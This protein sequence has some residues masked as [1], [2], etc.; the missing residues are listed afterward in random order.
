MARPLAKSSYTTARD[1]YQLPTP[2]HICTRK[3]A[4]SRYVVD[5]LIDSVTAESYAYGQ[6]TVQEAREAFNQQV[7]TLSQT[8]EEYGTFPPDDDFKL[9]FGQDATGY[10]A[11]TE[12]TITAWVRRDD[13]S[14]FGVA[15]GPRAPYTDYEVDPVPPLPVY[16]D[17]WR[18]RLDEGEWQDGDAGDSIVFTGLA[19]DSLHL[20]SALSEFGEVEVVPAAWRCAATPHTGLSGV[21]AVPPSRVV[22]SPAGAATGGHFV[23]TVLVGDAPI[24]SMVVGPS[25][26]YVDFAVSYT[27][28]VTAL[29]EYYAPQYGYGGA[30]LYSATGDGEWSAGTAPRPR[31]RPINR[32]AGTRRP[33]TTRGPVGV[34][35]DWIVTRAGL[36]LRTAVGTAR[37]GAETA[38][39][40][41]K[42]GAVAVGIAED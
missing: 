2:V 9:W 25:I 11:E 39:E 4:G 19:P 38:A 14:E 27:G 13:K 42:R 33:I 3:R 10:G 35:L 31:V 8:D 36:G 29:V 30:L 12:T 37:R 41:A 6:R 21:A 1:M 22:W 34:A 18:F 28:H 23:V 32:Q 5:T 26:G 7:P 20:V 24:G 15:V 16:L 17:V 40:T